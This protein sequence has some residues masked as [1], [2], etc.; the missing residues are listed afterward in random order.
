MYDAITTRKLR[1]NLRALLRALQ[2]RGLQKFESPIR[3][4]GVATLVGRDPATARAGSKR[5]SPRKVALRSARRTR[6]G[7][8]VGRIRA[9]RLAGL[10]CCFTSKRPWHPASTGEKHAERKRQKNEPCCRAMRR[11]HHPN[12]PQRKAVFRTDRA[13][14]R[15]PARRQR[16]RGIRKYWFW[17]SRS[18]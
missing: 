3:D 17:P 6:N 7:W 1:H 2:K 10:R 5:S 15:I 11:F 4:I 12:L 16:V 13:G 9:V 18:T 14:W 8:I